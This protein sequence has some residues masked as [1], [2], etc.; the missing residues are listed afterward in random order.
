V[1]LPFEIPADPLSR[2]TGILL[3]VLGIIALLFPVP[4]FHMI[5]WFFALLVLFMAIGLMQKGL[6]KNT[7]ARGERI[8][9]LLCGIAG[10]VAGLAILLMPKIIT[11]AAKDIIA[12]WAL[13]TGIGL[14]LYVF[15]SE[16]GFERS[17][18][19][20]TGLVLV[21][22]GILMIVV[23]VIVTDYLLI[24]ILGFFAI[25]IGILAILFG[26][27]PPAPKPEI[28]ARIYK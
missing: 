9:L 19:A 28:N 6:S 18:S 23:P 16:S 14:I 20:I 7:G 17:I 1:E 4:A 8:I 27:A 24:I 26:P 3:I 2:T 21:L 25:G 13:V 5:E 22:V 12:I 11:I 15:T 10:L